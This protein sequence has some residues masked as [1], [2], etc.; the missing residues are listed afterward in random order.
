ILHKN[1]INMITF[2]GGESLLRTDIFAILKECQR[3]NKSVRIISN[4]Y[5][6]NDDICR[7]LKTLEIDQILISLDGASSQTHDKFRNREGSFSRVMNAIKLCKR[8][9]IEAMVLTNF[10]KN[11]L[12]ERR[13]IFN[14]LRQMDVRRW[15]VNELKK[16]GINNLI[17]DELQ[18]D[19]SD[20]RELHNDLYNMQDNW[21][22]EIIF[23]SI[24]AEM[25]SP[26]QSNPIT[27]G[28]H[29]SKLTFALRPNGDIAPCVYLPFAIGN[30]LKDEDII[31][32]WSTNH[33][34]REI[35][36]KKAN[37]KCVQC[38]HFTKCRGGC[39]ARAYQ[40]FGNI[41]YPDPLCWVNE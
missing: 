40:I 33:I 36:N 21:Q 39:F 15:R 13:D 1:D 9:G 4:G 18:M 17:Y 12:H 10:N 37:G 20:I 11:N 34:V 24:F 8:Y 29:C 31:K 19:K 14:L 3:L 35:K 5:I 6:I 22:G 16:L 27:S 7:E 2:G 26:N 28:C 41:D 25:E 30:I 32:L 38:S 23:D